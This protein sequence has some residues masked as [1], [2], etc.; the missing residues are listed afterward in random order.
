MEAETKKSGLISFQVILEE[1]QPLLFC[2]HDPLGK[3]FLKASP[4]NIWPIGAFAFVLYSSV[5]IGGGSV[6]SIIYKRAGVKFLSLFDS[7]ELPVAIFAFLVTAPVIWLFYTWQPRGISEAFHQLYKN[8]VIGQPRD[9]QVQ[10]GFI[11]RDFWDKRW[12]W[13]SL[14]IVIVGLF[15]WLYGVFYLYNPFSFGENMYWWMINPFYFWAI[16]IPL[17]FINLYMMVWVIFRQIAVTIAF[18][19]VFRVFRVEPRL[20]HPDQCNGLA[21]VGDY[22]IRSASIA[23]FF[24]FWIFMFTTYPMLF[25]QPINLKIDTILLFAIYVIAVPSLL[26][27]P[28]MEA[29][30]AMVEAKNDLLKDLAEQIR[31]LLMETNPERVLISKDLL[32]ELERRY[33]LVRKE[34][35]TWPFRPLSIKGFGVSAIMPI[36]SMGISYLVDLYIRR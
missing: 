25:G 32:L 18:T 15:L 31:G 6:L 33:E 29:H 2:R 1:M 34:Y 5:M 24:G 12:F 9:T 11:L 23:I 16:W 7:R 17:V 10:I 22:A 21:P 3:L 28:V 13:L 36:L 20:L 4:R 26:L 35:R 14:V 27:P 30:K 8:G 19:Y